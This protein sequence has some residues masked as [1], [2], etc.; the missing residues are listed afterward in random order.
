MWVWVFN[1]SQLS[2]GRKFY[3]RKV[4][5]HLN[6]TPIHNIK[7]VQE[8]LSMLG[9]KSFYHPP[10]GPDLVPCNFFLFCVMKENFSGQSFESVGEHFLAV[11]AFLR[12]L[13]ADFC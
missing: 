8:H 6:N 10:D 11:G 12:G 7:E 1:G 5:A 4:A 3:E 2:G 13:S 9:F